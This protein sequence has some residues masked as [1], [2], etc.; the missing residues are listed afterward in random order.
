MPPVEERRNKTRELSART[1]VR[2]R[3]GMQ[4]CTPFLPLPP[5]PRPV[6]LALSLS[7]SRSIPTSLSF[8]LLCRMLELES[9]AR[10][11]GD[12]CTADSQATWLLFFHCS[13]GFL[14][15]KPTKGDL[16]RSCSRAPRG[17]GSSNSSD[18]VKDA[19]TP[20]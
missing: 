19:L 9:L 6:V 13:H 11:W 4:M 20:P 8:P 12:T 16:S 1:A 2:L 10:G 14:R 18:A 5:P 15:R 7:L 3:L 17:S